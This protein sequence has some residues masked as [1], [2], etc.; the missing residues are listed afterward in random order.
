MPLS[1]STERRRALTKANLRLVEA[2]LSCDGETGTLQSLV[3]IAGQALAVD[4]ALIYWICFAE[5]TATRLAEWLSP[6]CPVTPSKAVYPLSLFRTTARE[7]VRSGTWME[8]SRDQ[9]HPWLQED[10]AAALLHGELKIS[11]LLW[12]PFLIQETG[13]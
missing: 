7:L 2:L 5:D 1:P 8:S 9:V 11:R 13:L 12:Y 4:R 3:D 10:G 6:T